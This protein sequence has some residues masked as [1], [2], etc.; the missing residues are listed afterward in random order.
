MG[1]IDRI[2]GN[3]F[4]RLKRED[5]TAERIRLERSEKLK[6]ADVTR[7]SN[8]KKELFNKG[9]QVSEAERRAMARQMQQLDQKMKL[10]N[11]QLKRTSDQIRVVD[12]LIFIHENK[13]TLDRMG[14][15][16][17]LLRIPKSKLDEFLAQVNVKDQITAGKINELLITMQT[18][19]GLLEEVEDDK[20]TAKLMEIWA[21]SDVAEADE[22][23]KKWDKEKAAREKEAELE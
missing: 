2:K 10:D 21:T 8:Q 20:E 16:K 3:P 17:R 13:K 23:Y 1:I 11:I 15:M 4:E 19:Y 18:E 14:L 6:I 12:N 5:L 9:F 7:L 22:V